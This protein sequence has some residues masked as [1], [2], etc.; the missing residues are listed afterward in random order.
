[1]L[2]T[3]LAAV[4]V[5][6]FI[7]G[8]AFSDKPATG[9]AETTEQAAKLSGTF[10]TLEAVNNW[11]AK[12]SEM[13]DK[14]AKSDLVKQYARSIA[15]GNNSVDQKL[16]ATAQK[17]GIEMTPLNTQTEEGKSLQDRM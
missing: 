14:R 2:R 12:L 3:R 16:Q 17:H 9:G 5:P 7:S 13:A 8:V 4:I 11:S 15:A 10:S 1:M 6:L